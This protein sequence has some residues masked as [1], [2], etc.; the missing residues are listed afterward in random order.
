VYLEL[1]HTLVDLDRLRVFR[2]GQ[3]A[4][5]L[6]A[7]EVRLLRYLAERAGSVVPVDVLLRDVWEY[8]PR[9][10]SRTVTTTLARLRAKIEL[11]PKQPDHLVTVTGEGV[12]L[13][14]H[15][16]PRPDPGPL[17]GRDEALAALDPGRLVVVTGPV[18]IGR[19]RLVEARWRQHWADGEATRWV[20]VAGARS[21]PELQHRVARALHLADDA[22]LPSALR[23]RGPLRLVLDE[24]GG[25]DEDGCSMLAAW[26]GAA[27]ELRILA[28]AHQALPMDGAR[29]VRLGP[30]PPTVGGQLLRR[31][32]VRVQPSLSAA[33]DDAFVAVAEALDGLPLAL[34]LAARWLDVM[35]LDDLH[36]HVVAEGALADGALGAAVE[37]S[38][39]LLP[40]S[41]Q[42]AAVSLAVF[43][44]PFDAAAAARV[45]EVGPGALRS[46]VERGWVVGEPGQLRLLGALRG[47]L[48]PVVGEGVRRRHLRWAVDG[49]LDDQLA[50]VRWG[51]EVAPQQALTVAQALDRRL[52]DEGATALR[53]SALQCWD[54]DRFAVDPLSPTQRWWWRSALA[55]ARRAQGRLQAVLAVVPAELPRDVPVAW[56]AA[57]ERARALSERGDPTTD[58]VYGRARELAEAAGPAALA[59]VL[60][61]WSRRLRT[62]GR[63]EEAERA[64]I[65]GLAAAERGGDAAFLGL[66]W[67][68]LG[69]LRLEQARYDD[70]L[71]AFDAA[72]E[73]GTGAE[74]APALVYRCKVLI[75]LDRLDEAARGY[76]EALGLLRAEGRD[77]LVIPA[78]VALAEIHW[79]RAE[80]RPSLAR[81]DEA[82]ALARSLG[83]QERTVAAIADARAMVHLDAGALDLA[84]AQATFAVER[85]EALAE[86][87]HEVVCRQTLARVHHARGDRRRAA[88][89]YLRCVEGSRPGEG[90]VHVASAVWRAAALD[91]PDE[92]PATV[93][94]GDPDEAAAI[95]VWRAYLAAEPLP[96]PT[97]GPSERLARRLVEQARSPPSERA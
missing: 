68:T 46:L 57:L 37:R 48:A 1:R 32:A 73:V 65:A 66:A 63:L 29:E 45:A 62:L 5:T 82:E 84:L 24:L 87:R 94:V 76:D 7:T 55:S 39:Q 86:P 97:G 64:A 91:A 83:G 43:A 78:A 38:W 14:L 51:A 59:R 67:L 4:G 9:V 60:C 85:W 21:A 88:D 72:V 12:V 96:A 61:E 33:S 17:L 31:W 71:A 10:V 80:H 81:L 36:A 15:H 28:T 40:R 89:D 34:V 22:H 75:R 20:D 50:A 56:R 52:D 26:L 70:A 8:S 11:T 95:A 53:V 18:G 58:A 3:P 92:L 35:T 42:Q 19:S 93:R 79:R 47:F 27:P 25:L 49:G 30:L 6:T 41:L 13:R 74:R 77:N 90:P 69:N 54:P 2:V 23:A 16:P 44:G